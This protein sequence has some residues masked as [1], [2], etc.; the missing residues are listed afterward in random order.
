M[1]G[2]PKSTSGRS[3]SL[4]YSRN[5]SVTARTAV[6]GPVRTVVWQG[7]AGD[8]RPY[9]DQ[10]VEGGREMLKIVDRY[11]RQKEEIAEFAK[12]DTVEEQALKMIL[13]PTVKNAFDLTQEPDK[14][15]DR[16]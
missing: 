3:N 6:Y 8:R 10:V 16:Y 1:W 4:R 7:S 11:Y 12:M 15:K 9:A 13:S 14:V 5:A 2:F